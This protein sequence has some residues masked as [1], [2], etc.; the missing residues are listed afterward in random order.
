[1]FFK[2][3]VVPKFKEKKAL[4]RDIHE[5]IWHFSEGTTL[6]EVKKKI[7]WHDKTK[8]VRMVVK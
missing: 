2:N 3:L 1:L 7:F 4:V 6:V 5:D 8:T